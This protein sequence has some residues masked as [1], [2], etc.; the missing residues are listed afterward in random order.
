[1]R[2]LICHILS[3]VS[4]DK[5]TPSKGSWGTARLKERVSTVERIEKELLEM[6]TIQKSIYADFATYLYDRKQISLTTAVHNSLQQIAQ[7]KLGILEAARICGMAQAMLDA[8]NDLEYAVST[9]YLI[10]LR[11]EYGVAGM[12]E[13]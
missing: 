4:G 1:M 6:E 9:A 13:L 12:G 5:H 3:S 2:K 11:V 10:E 7:K 8:G